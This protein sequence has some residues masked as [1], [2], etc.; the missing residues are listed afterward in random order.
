MSSTTEESRVSPG[1]Q[2]CFVEP[3]FEGPLSSLLGVVLQTSVSSICMREASGSACFQ[4]CEEAGVPLDA[5]E[6]IDTPENRRRV[7]GALVCLAV[8]LSYEDRCEG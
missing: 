8:S 4:Y 3:R 2:Q 5:A 1:R 7:L 6:C